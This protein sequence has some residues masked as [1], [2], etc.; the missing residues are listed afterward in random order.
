MPGTPPVSKSLGLEKPIYKALFLRTNTN[1]FILQQS[2]HL[3]K[4]KF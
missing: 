3:V 1:D 2:E 4:G